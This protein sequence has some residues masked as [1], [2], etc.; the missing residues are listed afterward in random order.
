VAVNSAKKI[1]YVWLRET[2]GAFKEREHLMTWSKRKLFPV[3][4]RRRMVAKF[5]SQFLKRGP[6][7]AELLSPTNRFL[8]KQFRSVQIDCNVCGQRCQLVYEPQFESDRSAQKLSLLRE[9][10]QCG[11]CQSW[12]RIR[13]LA[14]GIIAECNAR[15]KLEATSIRQLA[16]SLNG[17]DILDTDSFG[18]IGRLLRGKPNY[19]VSDYRP[20]LPPGKMSNGA[21]NVNLEKIPFDDGSFDMIISTEVLEHVRDP[22]IAH[23]EVFRCL[24]PGGVHI[25][26]VPFDH[27]SCSTRTLIDASSPTDIYLELPQI[28]GDS[29]TTGIV[30]YRIYGMDMLAM[31]RSIGFDIS[32]NRFSSAQHGIFDE[33]Y[34]TAKKPIRA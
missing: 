7:A 13:A 22:K 5:A 2:A 28:H 32:L 21:Y 19:K 1:G 23:S 14:H 30:A 10:L 27:S 20:D 17:I 24:K 12:Q 9:N 15:Q 16:S 4:S 6:I 29:L 34:F 3:N 33:I 18:I 8:A 31:V 25:F 11:E 26:T